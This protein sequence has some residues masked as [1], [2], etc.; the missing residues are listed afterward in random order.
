LQKTCHGHEV[1]SVIA[2]LTTKLEFL[3]HCQ[4]CSLLRCGIAICDCSYDYIWNSHRYQ[5]AIDGWLKFDH[6]VIQKAKGHKT[7][8]IFPLFYKRY[9]IITIIKYINTIKYLLFNL[10]IYYLLPILFITYYL[11]YIFIIYYLAYLIN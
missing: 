9:I 2:N 4:G 8:G 11:G 10:A 7:C 3:I 6:M 1:E 5:C